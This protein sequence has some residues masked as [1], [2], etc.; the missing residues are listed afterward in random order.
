MIN[1]RTFSRPQFL[2]P[3]IA[4]CAAVSLFVFLQLKLGSEKAVNAQLNDVLN[5]ALKE[6]EQLLARIA[7]A[8]KTIQTKEQQL[9]R[10]SDAAALRNSLDNA[11]KVIEQLTADIGKVNGERSSLQNANLNLTAK[12]QGLTKEMTRNIEELKAARAE[13]AATEMTPLRK[14]ADELSRNASQKDQELAGLREEIKRLQQLNQELTQKNAQIGKAAQ[15]MR[16]AGQL[17]A[18]SAGEISQ[19]VQELKDTLA[20]KDEQIQRLQAGLDAFKNAPKGAPQ[21]AKIAELAAKNNDLLRQ[22][23]ELESRLQS[24]KPADRDQMSKLSELLV[25]KELQIDAAKRDALEELEQQKSRYEE[26][27]TLYSSLKTQVA[28]FSDALNLREAEL[29]QK[30]READQYRDEIA[31]M[32]ARVDSLEKE[33][34]DAKERQKKTLGDLLAAVRLN[35]LLQ[36]KINGDKSQ[37]Q[38]RLEAS[39]RATAQQKAD[40]LKRRI[41]IML[42]PQGKQVP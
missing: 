9:Q 21:Q 5:D 18:E 26:I 23:S 29:N 24:A 39:G 34:A 33:L 2:V 7:E 6:K 38:E 19:T 17:K 35:S 36:E 1:F 31:T 11:Q 20:Q 3:F 16:Q 12:I 8:E 32:H 42:E 37:P 4:V 15:D 41:E 10:L 27:S 25:K 28:Q 13:L 14:R 30:K 40:E 22:I